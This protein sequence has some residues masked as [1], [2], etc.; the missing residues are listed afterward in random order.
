[1][2][3]NKW[4]SPLL[5]ATGYFG[6]RWR[7]HAGG[8]GFTVVLCYHRVAPTPADSRLMT[9]ERGL[10]PDIFEAQIRFM[11]RHFEPILPRDIVESDGRKRLRFAVTFDDGYEDNATIAAPIL[12]RLGVKAAFYVVSDFAGSD[13]RFWWERVAAMLRATRRPSLDLQG[14]L[15]EASL[16]KPSHAVLSLT[17]AERTNH[18]HEVLCDYLRPL[19]PAELDA[20][21]ERLQRSLDVEVPESG[22]EFPLMGWDG[23]RDLCRRGFEVGCHTANH[24][25][26]KAAPPAQVRSEILQA[27]ERMKAELG[28]TPRTFA[29]PYGF[30]SRHAADIVAEAGIPLAFAEGPGVVD[31]RAAACALPRVQLNRRWPFAVSYNIHTALTA[32]ASA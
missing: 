25:N 29:Y 1:V 15:P 22:R 21:L 19:P 20:T 7:S 27:V 14:L 30:W 17:P 9:V 11:Q 8:D 26:L 23:L 6:R 18:A 5:H 13:R 12:E 28:D 32:A 4:L 10:A 24:H 2:N 3:L 31:A 16:P